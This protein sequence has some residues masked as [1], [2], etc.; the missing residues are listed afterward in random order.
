MY[1]NRILFF[2][3]LLSSSAFSQFNP[4]GNFIFGGNSVDEPVDLAVNQTNTA[5]FF[6]A[7]TFSSD[8]DVPGNAGNSDYW[9]MK[10][11]V[12][13]DPIWSQTYGSQGQDDLAAVMA[14][15]DGGVLGFGTTR[16]SQGLFGT[17]TGL[18]GGWLM[19]TNTNGNIING[20]IFGG[21]ITEIGIDAV[22]HSTGNIT[23][24]IE[25]GSPS[26][27]GQDNN[28]ILDVWVVHVNANFDIQWTSL[29]GGSGPDR[30]VAMATDANSNIY[31]VATSHSD[32]PGL[33]PNQGGSD[34]WIMKLAPNG[35]LLW[36]TTFGGSDDDEGS[37]IIFHPGGYVYVVAHSLSN[38]GD[39]DVND[40]INDLWMLRLDAEDGALLQKKS[41]GGTGNDLNGH[42][43]VFGSQHLVLTAT[44]TSNDLDLKG[45]KG[46]GDVWVVQT[47][48]TGDIVQQMNYGGSL[49]DQAGDIVIIDSVFHVLSASVSSDKNVP[50]NPYAQQDLWYHTLNTRP[51]TCNFNLLCIQDSTTTN[52][53]FPPANDVLLCASGCTAGFGPGPDLNSSGCPDFLNATSYY[54]LTTDTTAD[55]LTLSVTSNDFNQP[56]LALLR[57]VNCQSFQMVECTT[58]TNGLA[59]IQ[60][61]AVDPLTTYVVAVSDAE[62]NI[63]DYE[64]CATSIEVEFCNEQDRIFVTQTSKGS[65][66]NG[67]YLPG[68]EVQICYELQDWNK[69]DCNGFQGLVPTFGPG[70]DSTSFNLFGQPIQMDSLL[71]PIQTGFWAWYKVGDVRYNVSNPI[72]GYDGGQGMPAGWYFTN[73]GDPPPATNPDETTGDINSCQPSPGDRWKFCF[74]L[75]V[76]EECEENI[77]C[78]IGMKTFS[79]GEIGIAS[80]LACAYDQEEIFNAY[81]RCC[82]NPSLSPIQD[83]NICTGDTISFQ[84]ESNLAPPVTYTWTATP[85]PFVDG[86]SSGTNLHQF[87]QILENN[88]QIPQNIVYN[89]L[90]KN[91]ECQTPFE[92]FTIS[93]LPRPTASISTTGAIIVCSGTPVTFNFNCTGTPPFVIGL[94]RNNAPFAEILSE[95]TSISLPIDPE[96]SG[97]FRVG[98]LR[99]ANCEG[100]GTGFVDITVKPA[101]GSVV[102]TALCEGE[103]YF[104]GETEFTEA[105]TYTVTLPNGAENNCDSTITLMLSVIP[106]I[107]ET[108]DETIC[109]GDTLF[110]LNVPY[111]TSTEQ[112]IEYTGPEGCPNFIDLHLEVIDTFTMTID[113]T[114]CNGDTLEFEG[115]LVYQPGT[116]AHVEEIR[117]GCFEQTVLDLSVLPAILINDLAIIADDGLN[118][119]AILVEIVGGNPPFTFEWSN[120]Q[121]TESI[122]GIM[123]GD[124]SLTVTDALGCT[125]VFDFEVPM[126]SGTGPLPQ[127]VVVTIHPSIVGRGQT[128]FI[129]NKESRVLHLT[130]IH[131]WTPSGVRTETHLP[132]TMEPGDVTSMPVPDLAAGL[133]FLQLILADGRTMLTKIIVE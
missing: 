121:T 91:S 124:Y 97:R 65:P 95:S 33:D 14:H 81:M 64:L 62:G 54:Y 70:W 88:A 71:A 66:L 126:I 15:P 41:Y 10:R 111:T 18:A 116:Y 90:G 130:S 44:T 113:Q 89:I 23:L 118:N 60:Y 117:P 100:S 120:G 13:G 73:T 28:G 92:T 4:E 27:N 78:S 50:A 5:L 104:I 75:K 36:Q 86:A 109:N 133:Y 52:Q 101:S 76:V 22:R 35:D 40:G 98:E 47:S 34:L 55:L 105:G 12:N 63:G 96:F 110:V 82:L 127:D 39:F 122:F 80:S 30:P 49:N 43:A 99:D 67:P 68:E 48:L 132:R 56:K 94:Y 38:D 131:W 37:D 85:D 21:N 102:D 46:F 79:D 119:G 72:N 103:S 93:V 26:L 87:Y 2:F 17:L 108:I 20:K 6:G 123:Q 84:P 106:S 7:R 61:I 53:L 45:N 58:G 114:I 9:I 51:D 42:V 16:T 1:V 125:E 32:L 8:G 115:I 11:D 77:D 128:V 107:T 57:S 59:L 3:L 29:L 129:S 31:I 19:R 112:L 74:T 69:L 24:L 25:A 83:F